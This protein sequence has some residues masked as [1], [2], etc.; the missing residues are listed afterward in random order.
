[1]NP[2]VQNPQSELGLAGRIAAK[3]IAAKKRK[4]RK[5]R[6]SS[7]RNAQTAVHPAGKSA[8]VTKHKHDL[9]FA[10]FAPFCGPSHPGFRAFSS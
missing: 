7:Q 8:T 10:L 3:E 1:M 2:E 4:R 9:C 6:E 5:N